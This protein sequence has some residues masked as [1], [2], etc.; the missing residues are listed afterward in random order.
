M[1]EHTEEEKKLRLELERHAQE[2]RLSIRSGTNPLFY[3]L[4]KRNPS[5]DEEERLCRDCSLESIQ[6]EI[7]KYN[8]IFKAANPTCWRTKISENSKSTYEPD[9]HYFVVEVH[10]IEKYA[11]DLAQSEAELYALKLYPPSTSI[12]SEPQHPPHKVARPTRGPDGK[13]SDGRPIW[14]D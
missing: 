8:E 6:D 5:T 13:T 12:T 11:A 3:Y 2:W 4:A 1:I 7:A 10:E 9:P 14:R